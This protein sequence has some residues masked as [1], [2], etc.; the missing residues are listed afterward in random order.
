VII[1]D[2]LS[3]I[4]AAESHTPTKSPKTQTIRKMLDHEGPGITLLWVPSYKRI[5]GNKN[6]DQAVKEALVQDISTTERYPPDD[7]KKRLTEED[8]KKRDQRWK[9][10]NNEM[11]KG[12]QTWTER[13]KQKECQ[14]KSMRK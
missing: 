4:M 1:T 9:N 12:N 14:G 5:P 10:G 2:S 8:F 11:K 6:A 13:R 7:Q 3:T